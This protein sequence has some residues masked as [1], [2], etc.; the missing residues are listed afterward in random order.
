[1]QIDR[2]LFKASHKIDQSA[3]YEGIPAIQQEHNLGYR[4]RGRKVV[5]SEHS[6]LTPPSHGTFA[7]LGK[8]LKTRIHII[9]DVALLR[10]N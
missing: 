10:R 6:D 4:N 1:M 2:N 7:L 5:L 9:Y 3:K 8:E